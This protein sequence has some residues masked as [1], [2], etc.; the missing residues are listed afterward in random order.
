MLQSYKHV[1]SEH[2]THASGYKVKNIICPRD[3]EDFRRASYTHKKMLSVPL[4]TQER[5][6]KY[7]SHAFCIRKQSILK[8][9][10]CAKIRGRKIETN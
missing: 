9:I 7:E 3:G 2:S 8:V 4:N 1:P 6:P 5:S 10:G